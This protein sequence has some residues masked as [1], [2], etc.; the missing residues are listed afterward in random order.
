MAL[1]QRKTCTPVFLRILK[2]DLIS[3]NTSLKNFDYD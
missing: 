3:V 2:K 1:F